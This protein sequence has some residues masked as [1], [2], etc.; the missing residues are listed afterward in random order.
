MLVRSTINCRNFLRSTKL[1]NRLF[2][3]DHCGDRNHRINY[4]QQRKF[5]AV[6]NPLINSSSLSSLYHSNQFYCCS[7]SCRDCHQESISDDCDKHLNSS[8]EFVEFRE[9]SLQNRKLLAKLLGFNQ[10]F[11]SKYDCFVSKD[12]HR[13]YFNFFYQRN[14]STNDLE[15]IRI[16]YDDLQNLNLLDKISSSSIKVL[17]ETILPLDN[18]H[19]PG[20]L[21]HLL[22]NKSSSHQAK[23]LES[24][25]NFDLKKSICIFDDIFNALAFYQ[26]TEMPTIVIKFPKLSP[27][28][29]CD[30][31]VEELCSKLKD[32]FEKI[33]IW[34]SSN[35]TDFSNLKKYL[36]SDGCSSKI[37]LINQ[38]KSSWQMLRN[39]PK[40]KFDY[41][42]KNSCPIQNPFILKFDD[43]KDEIFSEFDDPSVNGVQWSRFEKLNEHFKGFR[44]GELTIIT[45]PTG[46]GKTTFVSE[47]SLD[48]CVQGV[49]TLWGS[50]EIKNVRLIKMMMTQLAQRN[51]LFENKQ[52]FESES[53]NF[54][55]LPMYFMKF[56]GQTEIDLF[57][58][59]AKHSVLTL[60]IKHIV[61]DNLQFMLGLNTDTNNDRFLR[62]DL[63]I[64]LLRQFVTENDCHITLVAHPRKEK[65]EITLSNNSLYGGIKASQEADNVMI[66]M[67]KFNA[68][69]RCQNIFKS[70]KIVTMVV[71]ESFHF[72][73]I[74]IVYVIRHHLQLHHHL[75]KLLRIL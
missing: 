20:F 11:L 3:D 66:I 1:I 34:P 70:L 53:K 15:N 29:S 67:N 24:I 71:W 23:T 60:G 43:L 51:L 72:I 10:T 41:V 56:H 64:G 22:P 36:L 5:S 68:R 59:A 18:T 65:E 47:Y 57:M 8:D 54:A 17:N 37:F 44:P 28:Q 62:Q 40:E 69:Y 13:I 48:L 30:D 42:I 61:I 7:I 46:C 74:R 12:L 26:Q 39:D 6:W 45:G 32:K 27:D 21:F 55:K 73:S 14:H 16:V 52:E 63:L 25:E 38:S 58:S 33:Y 75:Q 2:Q 31:I 35:G 49:P 50:F 4:Q 9:L 19:A